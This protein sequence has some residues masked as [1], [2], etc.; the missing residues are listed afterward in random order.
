[1]HL[2]HLIKILSKTL[3]IPLPASGARDIIKLFKWCQAISRTSAIYQITHDF[4]FVFFHLFIN[5]FQW[6]FINQ[7]QFSKMTG[8]NS[9]LLAFQRL[10]N[11][12][13]NSATY[14]KH[15]LRVCLNI[16]S[17]SRVGVTLWMSSVPLFS[18]SFRIIKIPITCWILRSHVSPQLRC[19]GTC[20]MLKWFKEF[21][22]YFYKTEIFPKGEINEWSFGDPHPCPSARPNNDIPIKVKISYKLSSS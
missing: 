10:N 7:Q 11:L 13:P 12:N 3:Q 6:Y 5:N 4:L 14:C 16:V 17:V 8:E 9:E 1:M 20:Q 2:Q 15:F 21:D 18:S 22:R 19:G